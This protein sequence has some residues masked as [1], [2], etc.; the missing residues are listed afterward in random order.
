MKT[1]F[2]F[3]PI[4]IS[5]LLKLLFIYFYNIDI[6]LTTEQWAK[7]IGRISGDELRIYEYAVLW[8][9]NPFSVHS[10]Y[11]ISSFLLN[12]S[13]LKNLIIYFFILKFLIFIS[14]VLYLQNII[15]KYF[16][17]IPMSIVGI[18]LLFSPIINNFHLSLHRDDIITSGMLLCIAIIIDYSIREK[19]FDLKTLLTIFFAFFLLF[20]S[21]AGLSFCFIFF[22]ISIYIIQKILNY[23]ISF[24]NIWGSIS[25]LLFL[26]LLYFG[27]TQNNI[28]YQ[29]INYEISRFSVSNGQYI[30]NFI[31]QLKLTFFSPAPWNYYDV[32]KSESGDAYKVL[33]W[34]FFSVIMNIILFPLAI[35]IFIKNFNLPKSSSY[36][37]LLIFF[38]IIFLS[39]AIFSSGPHSV[40]IRQMHQCQIIFSIAFIL[41][42]NLKKKI[43]T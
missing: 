23:K 12:I 25:F 36:I 4:I 21:R 8:G 31:D 15:Y 38:L 29:T 17:L 28:I 37:S 18:Y 41:S 22:L 1:I 5:I 9:N 2:L 26:T 3:I 35:I 20:F 40:G 11:Q 19:A 10:K 14:C 27:Y 13:G 43:R 6:F 16:G 30:A 32:L 33:N 34:Y 42:L 39:F 7:S 24:F